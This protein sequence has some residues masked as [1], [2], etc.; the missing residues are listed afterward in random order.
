[1]LPIPSHLVNIWARGDYAAH[2][3]WL[4]AKGLTPSHDPGDAVP[5]RL[6]LKGALLRGRDW[7]G[8]DF[9]HAILDN[10]DLRDCTWTGVR[11]DDASAI[12][13]I[14]HGANWDNIQAPRLSALRLDGA[15]LNAQGANLSGADFSSAH[16]T[17]ANF[18]GADLAA[19][20]WASTAAY[21]VDFRSAD[22]TDAMLYFTNLTGADLRNSTLPIHPPIPVVVDIDASI[23]KIIDHLPHLLNQNR[24]REP[25]VLDNP[26]NATDRAGWAIRLGGQQGATLAKV[27]GPEVAA[28]LIYALNR[29]NVPHPDFFTPTTVTVRELRAALS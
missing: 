28:T 24:W 11:L 26:H 9:R 17:G 14:V 10:A 12:Q 2:Q 7:S 27:Y 23:V 25:G 18:R 21:R 19:T 8:A 4:K 6:D 22:L 15:N 20:T 29:P 16:L 1:M 13:A 3:A 5:R